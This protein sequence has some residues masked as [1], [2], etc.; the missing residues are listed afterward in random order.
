M[1]I[2]YFTKTAE[3]QKKLLKA[4][5]LEKKTKELLNIIEKD[6]FQSPPPYEKLVGDLKGKYSRRINITHR[7][8]YSVEDNII[9]ISSMWTHYEK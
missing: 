4:A 6:P 8:V 1:Y 7:L 9:R 2:I 5:G 3:K